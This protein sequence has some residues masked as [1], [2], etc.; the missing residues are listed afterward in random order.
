MSGRGLASLVAAL[1]STMGG[2]A[3]GAQMYRQQQRQDKL[4]AQQEEEYQYNKGQRDKAQALDTDISN[5]MADRTLE[6]IP[7][8]ADDAMG[9]PDMAMVPPSTTQ[10]KVDGQTYADE[11]Q[12]R[13]ALAGVNS[14][15]S[16]YQRA[17]AAA[18]AHGAAGVDKAAQYD[19][20]A[21]QALNE[22]TDQIISHIQ[23][24]APSLAEVKKAG[25]MVA[26][27]V[28]EQAANVFNQTGGRWKVGADT[29]TQYYVDKDAAG[30]EFVNA[31]VLGQDGKPIVDDVHHAGLF[32]Q[33]Y[34]TRLEA[35]QGDTR[36]YQTGQQI[37]QTGQQ[38]AEAA[39][40][41][42]VEEA[43]GGQRNSIAAQGVKLEQ[44]KFDATTPS[45]KISGI[46]QVLGSPMN[47]DQK[48]TILGV[49]RFS[50]PDQLLVQSLLKEREQMDQAKAK[51]MAEGMWNPNSDG[52]KEMATQSAT[53]TL[54]LNG[55]LSKYGSG[56][57]KGQPADPLNI[58]GDTGK[59][60]PK[61]ASPAARG[62]GAVAQPATA[63]ATVVG[64]AVDVRNDP[65]LKELNAGIARLAGKSDPQSVQQLM[66]LGTAKNARIEQLR[67]NFG[68]M[69]NLITE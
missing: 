19:A 35:Q 69:S 47:A 48:M 12:A 57:G 9:N 22:G 66:D 21:K 8:R 52:A 33:D 7:G 17:A 10:Y 4:D 44:A 2:Y 63:G 6:T 30:R 45:G 20:F 60:E 41:N 1:G 32:L 46:E 16:K 50:Q 37:A 54:K 67:Q 5:A 55:I 11:G 27:T 56:N 31:R 61:A 68:S 43:L 49:S 23:S 26:G 25:G 58:M 64:G 3:Q 34:K 13:Q 28:G 53:I 18:A 29:T 36:A 15:A 24:A 40:H 38:I 62:V 65:A 42:K 51:A 14:K 39:R 59:A